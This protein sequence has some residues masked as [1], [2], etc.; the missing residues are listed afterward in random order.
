MRRLRARHAFLVLPVL[1]AA[2]VAGCARPI[3][4]PRASAPVIPN[5]IREVYAVP[6]AS[7]TKDGTLYQRVAGAPS[8]D[9]T[10]LSPGTGSLFVGASGPGAVPHLQWYVTS[11]GT[12]DIAGADSGSDADVS[13]TSAAPLTSLDVNGVH[14]AQSDGQIVATSSGRGRA[15]YALPNLTPDKTVGGLPRGY[16]AVYSA[17]GPGVVSALVPTRAGHV[18]A[19]SSTGLAS[20]V[21]DLT[22][23]V[24]VPLPGYGTLGN[25]LLT[26]SGQIV[27]LGWRGF[28][29]AF[30]IHV[31]TLDG[32]SYGVVAD[33]STGLTDANYLRDQ[34]IADGP[35]A[36][37]V[38]IAEGDDAT[39][40]TLTILVVDKGRVVGRPTLPLNAG[41]QIA[42]ASDGS[43]YVFNGPARNT[44]GELDV[45]TGAFHADLASLRVPS[46]SYV[47]GVYAA[48]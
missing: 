26:A 11:Q 34:V 13:E 7:P 5:Q 29:S 35:D 10:L 27:V 16:K 23:G 22:T 33:V 47:V 45:S 19:F 30:P 38:S 6:N 12:L 32:S 44:V 46:G 18:L 28:D 40:V 21:T 36:A 1:I 31:L 43:I 20:A 42:P 9:D 8:G 24:S 14:Y 41:L 4:E 39:G 3:L 48:T 15:T 17:Q 2:S 37:V 25:A